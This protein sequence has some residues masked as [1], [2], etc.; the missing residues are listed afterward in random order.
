ME[1]GKGVA[2][3]A[4]SIVSDPVGVVC[5]ICAHSRD[6]AEMFSVGSGCSH[7][8]CRDCISNHVSTKVSDNVTVIK[9]PGLE[10]AGVFEIEY[11]RGVVPED[12]AIRW[13]RVRCEAMFLES[14]KLYCPFKDCSAMLIK[15][16]DYGENDGDCKVREC[17]CPYCHRLFC[18]ACEV[19]WHAGVTCE[20]YLAL[21]EDERGREDLLV[22]ELALANKWGRCPRCKYYVERTQGCPHI[23]C[24]CQF[25]FCYGCGAAWD[26]KHG[27]CAR[28]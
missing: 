2:G 24:R 5:E 19:P 9:C 11:C 10:C 18:A 22:W 16:W 20:E 23:T 13:E 28:D 12:L 8:F 25:E 17:E 4:E 3:G 14:Q 27:G 1:I 7:S 15:D 26:D 21:G 6:E